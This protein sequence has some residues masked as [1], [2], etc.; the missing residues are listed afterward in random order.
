M[1][2]QQLE[3]FLAVAETGSFSRAAEQVHL[4]QPALSR[5][6]LALEEELGSPLFD[7]LGRRNELTQAGARIAL[8]ARRVR[9]E[10]TELRRS[11]GLIESL[12]AGELRVGLGP[13]PYEMLAA[14]TLSH[15][16]ARHPAIK[17]RLAAGAGDTMLSSLRKR[18]LDAVVVH[19]RF[20]PGW[21]EL[22]VTM[23]PPTR[24]GF[25]CRA[26]HALAGRRRL[27]YRDLSTY[28]LVASGNGLS[29]EM[30]QLL[31]QR[32]GHEAH[33]DSLIQYQSDE[34]SC[35]LELARTS[36]AVFFGVVEAARR[37]L[38]ARQL[39]E[40]KPAPALNLNSQFA[41]LTLGGVVQPPAVRKLREIVQAAF[42]TR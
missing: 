11:V 33:F 2:L 37:F 7:R 4:T 24:V 15:F 1:N 8:H 41:L 10:L 20:L 34:I 23:L 21:E 9:L 39:V 14:R 16:A 40:L 42:E 17:I 27:T 28:P 38:D 22:E 30:V 12:D 35:L 29:V 25:V 32:F 36:D 19:K 26:K 3:H 5:S 31:N 18:E 6:I 13:A